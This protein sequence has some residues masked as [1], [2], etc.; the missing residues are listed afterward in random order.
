MSPGDR[1]RSS[2]PSTHVL[3][4]LALDL[5]F[6]VRAFRRY[7]IANLALVLLLTI[8]IGATASVLTLMGRVLLAPL[9]VPRPDE[10][11]L[12]RRITPT[13]TRADG[14]SL[15][16]GDALRV[17]ARTL[18]ALTAYDN[19]RLDLRAGAVSEPVSGRLLSGAG[20]AMLGVR[21]WAGRSLGTDDDR[22]GRP[23]VAMMSF[24]YW[25]RRFAADL[26]VIGTTVAVNGTPVTIVG[27][28][29]PDFNGLAV[30]EAPEDLWLPMAMHPTFALKDHREV[31]LLGRLGR[32]VTL[33][34][35]AAE[36]TAL[37][38]GA[39]ASGIERIAD[40]RDASRTGV[41][42]VAARQGL[43]E[44]PKM[45]SWPL[46]LLLGAAT[47]LL[48]VICANG[49]GLLA[50]RARARA[51]EIAVRL[52]MGVSRSRLFQQLLVENALVTVLGVLL[53]ALA[54]WW[55]TPFLVRL[56]VM[57]AATP[58]IDPTPDARVVVAL[59]SFA[60]VAAVAFAAIQVVI[61]TRADLSIAL[62]SGR[63]QS[64]G[65]SV[66]RLGRMLV[67]GQL[68]LSLVLVLDSLLVADAVRRIA[69]VDPGFDREHV[70][71][72]WTF[73]GTRGYSGDRERTLYR[74]LAER[75][76]AAPG[77]R[78]ASV[79]RYRPGLPRRATC[80]ASDTP[81]G[82]PDVFVN[83]V[84]PRYFSTMGT[85]LVAGREFA[86]SDDAAAPA[87]AIVAQ[88]VAKSLFEGRSPIGA[89]ML[90]PN[91]PAHGVEVVGVVG[92]AALYHVRPG[93]GTTAGCDVYVPV[94]QASA[95]FLGQM[96][97]V[98]RAAADPAALVPDLRAILASVDPSLSLG[99]PTTTATLVHGYYG[100]HEALSRFALGF[101][102]VAILV[103]AVGL[104][105]VLALGVAARL[106]ELGIRAALGA[107]RSDAIG[108]IM[109]E[110]M[111]VLVA[112][113]SIGLV[114]SLASTRALRG[115]V[116]G[117]ETLHV[118]PTLVSLTVLALATLAAAYVPARRAALVD[119][120]SAL[121][122]E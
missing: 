84:G 70:I 117:L 64:R 44:L 90:L 102:G 121:R 57:D 25:Q 95:G 38:R 76:A 77:A 43:A 23:A 63:G 49:A 119:P 36:L 122:Q 2:R 29:R 47:L 98:V 19:T 69:R 112:G 41:N 14:F 34:R 5:R 88:R 26:D 104:Y 80:R 96:N 110:A 33:A 15:P 106:R 30:G 101:S 120:A 60:V 82:S 27:V 51:H 42:V 103:A 20:F 87:V 58:M 67:A 111:S 93:V 114:A 53:G 40:P 62:R 61:A 28:L 91:G 100:R 89:R 7:A 12:L 3:E 4:T 39:S 50:A 81:G 35:A 99:A 75:F 66:A 56:L 22:P 54:A 55:S 109:A 10:L 48:L 13:G 92:D 17:G 116:F 118:A 97:V 68:A 37:Y 73:A 11:V 105:G 9:P 72:A 8:G 86:W 78:E 83:A 85:R 24:A 21:P 94:A 108:L 115:A 18:S 46:R 59:G 71:M 16:V 6:G 113:G 74:T 32:D 65:R 107:T 45:L 1:V 31:G 52:A 79:V